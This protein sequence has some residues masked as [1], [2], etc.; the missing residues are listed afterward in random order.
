MLKTWK[1][2]QHVNN[3]KGLTL[4]ELLAV[5]VILAIIA[6]IAVPTIG[7]VIGNSRE[8]AAKADVVII[9]NSANL[10]FSVNSLVN[11]VTFGVGATPNAMSFV[12]N[13]GTLSTLTVSKSG[14]SFT[15]SGEGVLSNGVGYTIASG[16][17]LEQLGID[18][19]NR[20]NDGMIIEDVSGD[21]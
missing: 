5:I 20:A 14:N 1:R 12:N 16:T 2:V 8:K 7:D 13:L 4:I 10:Y 11:S 21:S 17:T 15:F 18:Q 9:V 6:A 19:P 3:P